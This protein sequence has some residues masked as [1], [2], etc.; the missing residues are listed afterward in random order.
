MINRRNKQ[1]K[2]KELLEQIELYKDETK[3]R[4]LN[5]CGYF[6]RGRKGRELASINRKA[7][8]ISHI[9]KCNLR[10]MVD[11]SFSNATDS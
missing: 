2:G 11:F 10:L 6:E 7:T 8:V 4:I 9:K 1:L 5:Q 3:F